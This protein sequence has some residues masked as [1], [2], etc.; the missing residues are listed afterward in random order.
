MNPK[1]KRQ[2][3]AINPKKIDKRK[4]AA[5]IGILLFFTLI[6]AIARLN[7]LY[8]NINT[9]SDDW[10]T[11]VPKEKKVFN[12]LLLGYGGPGHDGAYLTDT[13]MFLSADTENK[14]ILLVSIPRDIWVQIP[15]E[16]EEVF[17]SKINSAYQTGLFIENY[18]AVDDSYSG[19]QGAGQL[20]KDIIK[21]VIGQDVDYY[22]AIDFDGFKQAVDTLGGVEIT[23]ERSFT[24]P[25]YPV[26]GMADD[27]CGI[28]PEDTAAFEEQEKIATESPQLAYPCRYETLSFQRGVQIMDGTTALKFVRSRH[29]AQ[30]GGDFGRARRQ[31]LFLEAVR[32]KVLSIGFIP[33]ILP[34]MGDLENNVRTDMPLDVIQRLLGEAAS[35]REYTIKQVVLTTDNYL[36]HSKSSDGQFILVSKTDDWDALQSDIALYMKGISPSPSPADGSPSGTSSGDAPSLGS[37]PAKT[38]TQ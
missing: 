30:D 32:D 35:A 38:G 7:S 11:P 27:L 8:S 13:I 19:E 3:R 28:D 14:R 15:T 4:L 34:L 18:P 20:L 23:V 22:V 29:S 2:S 31:Q 25:L 36:D 37:S 33:K 16:T 24:D 21:D 5:G 9:L 17:M 26:D 12:T 1:L 6:F 10:T